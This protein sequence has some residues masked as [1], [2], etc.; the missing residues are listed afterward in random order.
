MLVA[1][2]GV[3][4]TVAA[5]LE[6]R[7]GAEVVAMTLELWADPANDGEASCCSASAVRAARA[8]AHAQ[9]IHT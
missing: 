2:G 6:R 1:G 3:D 5:L 7:G 9:G 8:L 4:S